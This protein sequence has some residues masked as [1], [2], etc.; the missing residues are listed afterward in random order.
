[1]ACRILKRLRTPLPLSAP[2]KKTAPGILKKDKHLIL[3]LFNENWYMFWVKHCRRLTER[4][5]KCNTSTTKN[6]DPHWY[7]TAPSEWSKPDMTCANCWIECVIND[8]VTVCVSKEF[9]QSEMTHYKD[10]ITLRRNPPDVGV[11]SGQKPS[12]KIIYIVLQTSV[13]LF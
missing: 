6:L 12:T 5:T 11:T 2:P 9:L 3:P 7:V 4:K 10:S 1:M 13:G 8:S